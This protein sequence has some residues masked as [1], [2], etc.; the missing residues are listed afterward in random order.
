MRA[1]YRAEVR[2]VDEQVGR[3]LRALEDAGV[4]D[5]TMVVVTSDHG[6]ALGE[7]DLR[8]E[9]TMGHLDALNEHLWTVPLIV[10]HP[11]VEP[12][13]V[14][15][16]TSLRALY[17]LLTGDREAFLDAGG[18]TWAEYFDDDLV[19]FELPANPYHEESMR[20]REHFEDWFVERES[21]THSVMGFDGEWNVVADSRGEV[22][23]YRG[24]EAVDVS[25]APADLRTACEDA[26][27]RFPAVEGDVE[28]DLSGDVEQQLRDLGYV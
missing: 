23:A 1:A 4:R 11:D 7:T 24:D 6:E 19:F 18:R 26:V 21:L 22:S 25:D 5:E 17:D 13:T 20:R 9:R 12:R 10:A 15:D 8:G 27:A 2:S 16:R 14:E 28:S 3:L